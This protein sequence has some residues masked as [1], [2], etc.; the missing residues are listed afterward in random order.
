MVVEVNL[1]TILQH[2]SD[3]GTVRKLNMT[4]PPGAILAEVLDRLEIPLPEEGL[5]LVV[6]GKTAEA[7]S[8]LRDGDIIHLIPALSGG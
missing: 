7:T 3:K 1:H 2:T 5:I 4:L 6:N 8:Q